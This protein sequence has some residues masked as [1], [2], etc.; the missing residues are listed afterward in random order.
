MATVALTSARSSTSAVSGRARRAR[1]W[2]RS[3]ATDGTKVRSG[4]M[5]MW[6]SPSNSG[7]APRV[8]SPE[9]TLDSKPDRTRPEPLAESFTQPPITRSGSAARMQYPQL[10]SLL[11]PDEDPGHGGCR[12]PRLDHSQGPGG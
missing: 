4:A 7:N 8:P 11:W 5:P 3:D 9:L 6:T 12:L 10:V 1:L 2:M